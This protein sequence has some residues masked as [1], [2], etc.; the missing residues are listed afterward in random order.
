MTA[1]RPLEKKLKLRNSLQEFSFDLTIPLEFHLLSLWF[2]LQASKNL[3]ASC[4]YVA[5]H[6][7][8]RPGI[9]LSASLFSHGYPYSSLKTRDPPPASH[10]QVSS[11]LPR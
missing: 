5:T 9:V 4:L 3:P 2:W 11:S 10:R 8:P 7:V 6:T 1:Y